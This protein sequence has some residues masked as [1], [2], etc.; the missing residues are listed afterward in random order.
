MQTILHEENL[1]H[2]ELLVVNT[3]ILFT[4]LSIHFEVLYLLFS[5][6]CVPISNLLQT[7]IRAK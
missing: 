4:V 5:V 2:H 1:T 3:D 6:M 7:V